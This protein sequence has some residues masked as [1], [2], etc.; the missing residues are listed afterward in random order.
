M[1][2]RRNN[3]IGSRTISGPVNTVEN[4][5]HFRALGHLIKLNSDG[6]QLVEL[7]KPPQGPYGFYLG[8]GNANYNHGKYV[9]ISFNFVFILNRASSLT[10]V[11]TNKPV[12]CRGEGN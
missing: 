4:P 2:T 9:T 11:L 8:R 7:E 6:S 12:Q 10:V 1:A 5:T 3:D